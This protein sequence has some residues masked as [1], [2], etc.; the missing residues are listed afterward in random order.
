MLRVGE[1]IGPYTLT[2]KLGQGAFGAVWLAERR[3]SITT[4]KVALKSPLSDEIDLNA[5]KQ[6]AD[7]WVQA[8]GHPN[9]IPIIEANVYD[10]RV[11]IVSEY[12]PGG[13]LAEWQAR[14]RASA[15]PLA[16]VV[17]IIS[18]I[19]SGLEHLHAR[20][21][22]HRDLKP[23][24]IL[25][26]G[27]IPRLTDFGISRILKTTSQ[28]SNF[29]GTPVY[30]APEA[31]D[32]KRSPQTDL[33][34]VGVIFYEL[35]A[36][37]LPFPQM[38]F[39]SLVGAVISRNPDPLPPFVPMPFQEIVFRALQKNPAQR[40]GS[41]AEMRAALR[42]VMHASHTD[43]HILSAKTEISNTLP[44]SP[45]PV[46]PTRVQPPPIPTLPETQPVKQGIAP[47]YVYA[48]TAL[49]AAI[50]LGGVMIVLLKPKSNEPLSASGL[51]LQNKQAESSPA[52]TSRPHSP[53]PTPRII[54][55]FQNAEAKILNGH[56]LSS[57]DLAGLSSDDLRLLRNTVFARHGRLF[58]TPDI[59]RYFDGRAWYTRRLNFDNADL[60]ANDQA[61][62]KLL[63]GADKY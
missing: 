25:L 1:S 42:R 13:T 15:P 31:F 28:S 17:E 48:V 27:E 38:D 12:A 53:T 34:A 61:N 11:V 63:Q 47:H 36:G 33:W 41:A 20:N 32:G 24:N 55:P 7:L 49:L 57:A 43:S 50:I 16:T 4:T 8:S 9:V 60:T 46:P 6:E 44:E 51:N 56:A 35:L 29:A 39:T 40:Y 3:T 26:Q 23:A 21:I 18:G 10:G 54:S 45:R 37:R 62:V 2:N 52:P 30:M 58:Q 59:Q 5:V 19:L 22:I 14:F